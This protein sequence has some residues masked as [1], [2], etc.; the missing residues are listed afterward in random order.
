MLLCIHSVITFDFLNVIQFYTQCLILKPLPSQDYVVT[1]EST[2][3]SYSYNLTRPEMI[4]PGNRDSHVTL[5]FSADELLSI[6]DYQRGSVIALIVTVAVIF[7]I[8]NLDKVCAS[9]LLCSITQ[10]VY[11]CYK[12]EILACIV[13]RIPKSPIFTYAQT[14]V[15]NVDYL[16]RMH[17]FCLYQ[18]VKSSKSMY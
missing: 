18:A 11:S 13:Y 17:I 15:D 1:L 5:S 2:F 12:A 16:E 8:F 14:G 6:P 9:I 10:H 7:A 4:V 3:S